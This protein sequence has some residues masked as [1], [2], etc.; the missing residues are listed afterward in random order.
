MIAYVSHQNVAESTLTIL[1]KHACCIILI[2]CHHSQQH[3][4]SIYHQHKIFTWP[5]ISA[6]IE[7]KSLK[8]KIHGTQQT[9][10]LFWPWSNPSFPP[11]RN[12]PGSSSWFLQNAEAL[13]LI[14]LVLFQWQIGIPK[15]RMPIKL[16]MTMD[17]KLVVST[18]LKNMSQIGSFP[19]IGV[20][21]KNIWNHPLDY[22]PTPNIQT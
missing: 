20:K 18:H 14:A 17:Y 21:I 3:L 2:I 4:L 19:Q 15:Q 5:N 22:P 9:S 1:F 8:V 16:W 12:P 10:P 11:Q 13:E 7:L 6:I